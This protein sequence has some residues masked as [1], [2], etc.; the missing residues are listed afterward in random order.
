MAKLKGKAKEEFLRRMARGRR[1]AAN[2]SAKKKH[3]AARPKK[4]AAAKKNPATKPKKARKKL[5]G[6]AKEEFLRRMARGRRKAGKA[7]PKRKAPKR[8]RTANKTTTRKR[9]AKK[10]NARRR[11][12]PDTIEA[13]AEKF[14]EFHGK[15]PGRVIEYE[16][17]YTYPENLAEMGKLLELRFHLDSHNKHFPLTK[18][19]ACQAVCTPDGHNIYFIGGDQEIDLEALGISSTKDMVELGNCN[20]IAYHTVKGFH[21]FKPTPYAHEFGEESGVLPMLAYDRLN[22]TLFL[23]GGDFQVRPEGIVN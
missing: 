20:Y 21:D 15:A 5:T 16:G 19:G 23:L 13:A 6:K 8:K 1:K 4:K 7:N 12:N 10:T 14:T 22:K 3:S 18:F 9:A 11:R 17:T 2:G